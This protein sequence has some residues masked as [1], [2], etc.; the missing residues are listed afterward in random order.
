MTT[1]LLEESSQ[2]G[3]WWFQHLNGYHWFVFTIC[4]LGW[5]FDCADQMI[6][7]ISRSKALADLIHNTPAGYQVSLDNYRSLVSGWTTMAFMLGWATG[8]LIFGVIGDR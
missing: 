3:K 5:M 7:T 4:A 1:N 2:T 6:F 8:G